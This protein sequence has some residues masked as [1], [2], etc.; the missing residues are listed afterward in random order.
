MQSEIMYKINLLIRRGDISIRP[1]IPPLEERPHR[2]AI[3]FHFVNPRKINREYFTESQLAT[4][5]NNTGN[6]LDITKIGFSSHGIEGCL[7]KIQHRSRYVMWGA[8]ECYI[9]E[10]P[11]K[12]AFY[13]EQLSLSIC[14]TSVA[15]DFGEFRVC[16]KARVLQ[17]F[18]LLQERLNANV[19]SDENP[20]AMY[21]HPFKMYHGK[22]DCRRGGTNTARN[23]QGVLSMFYIIDI[24]PEDIGLTENNIE[25]LKTVEDFYCLF[26]MIHF[27]V[28]F[29]TD[30]DSGELTLSRL[31]NYLQE[32][33]V[34][35]LRCVYIKVYNANAIENHIKNDMSQQMMFVID[36][37]PEPIHTREC[38][39][40][41][42]NH[43]LVAHVERYIENNQSCRLPSNESV[44]VHN[45]L[46][47]N[48]I[49]NRIPSVVFV[50][51]LSCG[52][53]TKSE[54]RQAI[55]KYFGEYPDRLLDR[56]ESNW[57]VLRERYDNDVDRRGIPLPVNEWKKQHVLLHHFIHYPETNI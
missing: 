22:V 30:K 54:V 52:H 36:G 9:L 8:M 14:A 24:D 47:R 7:S 42:N 18:S 15:D 12:M 2:N 37:E 5:K 16:G 4:I 31:H 56:T 26:T 6:L 48:Y 57:T 11:N 40:G 10:V 41:V 3:Y 38:I 27:G 43:D 55:H 50:L 51:G 13:F 45:P 29:A 35:Q 20:K 17:W 33:P 44:F 34:R 28:S 32:I 21:L 19:V 1:E 46:T 53:I 25:E 49:N 39:H 23:R